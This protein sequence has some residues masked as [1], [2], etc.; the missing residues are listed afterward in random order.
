[1]KNK[2]LLLVSFLVLVIATVTSIRIKTNKPPEIEVMKAANMLAKAQYEKSPKFAKE[3]FHE[4][5]FHYNSAM[6]EWKKQ[7]EKFI[8]LRDYRKVSEFAK[9]SM[10]YS[11]KAIDKS[12]IFIASTEDILKIRIETIGQKIKGFEE[13]Y[14]KFPLDKKRD[15]Y[16]RCKL[17]YTESLHAYNSKNYS[18]CKVKLDS[19]EIVINDVFNHC[20]ENLINY[21]EDYSKWNEMVKITISWSKK[22]Q[23]YAV[24]VDK[25]NRELYLYK[26]GKP[27]KK[28]TV[29]LGANWIGDK[30]QQG[31]KTTPEGLYKIVEKK[32]NGQTK[33]Y[34]ALLLDYPNEEDKKRFSMNKRNGILN[35]DAEIG[36]LIEIHGSGGKGIDW[37]D[38][39]IALTD[40]EMDEIFKSCTIGTKVTIVGSVKTL[41]ELSYNIK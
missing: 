18:I 1:M 12:R 41:S 27:D 9:K 14:G 6:T 3:A 24:I 25:L 32:Q 21:F 11:E 22:N 10:E 26:N 37:T 35:Q 33:Y 28:Y 20:Q 5:T 7:N 38:G 2:I 36:N 31:D 39:C 15:N 29:E 16:T 23:S 30:I 19:V 34:K 13:Y 17:L 8:L 4:A 40:K